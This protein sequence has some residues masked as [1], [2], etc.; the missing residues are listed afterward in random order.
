I[1]FAKPGLDGHDVGAKVVVQA[2][3]D[4]GFDVIYTGLRKSPEEIVRRACEEEVDV[5]G[6]S[7][8]SGSH[9]PICR[10][11]KALLDEHELQDVLWIVGGNI[12][13]RDHEELLKLGVAGVFSVGTP[14]QT[15]VDFIRENVS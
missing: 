4:A 14:L 11:L 6:L 8:L 1:L 2:L 7:I 3:R 13:D 5:I 9:I 10:Q 12:P 15:I